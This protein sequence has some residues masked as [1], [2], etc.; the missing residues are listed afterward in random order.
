MIDIPV[1][2]VTEEYFGLFLAVV[3]GFFI[4]LEREMSRKMAGIR[5][6]TFPRIGCPLTSPPL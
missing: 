4:G 6:F 3:L 1:S 2:F 5:T